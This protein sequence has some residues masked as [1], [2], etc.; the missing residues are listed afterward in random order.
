MQSRQDIERLRNKTRI[1]MIV[2]KEADPV[3]DKI[4]HNLDLLE[5]KY[6]GRI[7]IIEAT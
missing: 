5:E 1:G 4:R 7:E 6:P 3:G 2:G